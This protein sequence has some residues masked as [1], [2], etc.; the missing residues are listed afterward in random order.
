MAAI[1]IHLRR[2][3]Q[4]RLQRIVRKT[5]D[6]GL[7][8]RSL[9]ILHATA[10]KSTGQIAEAIGYDPSAVLKVIHRFRAEGE[11]GLRDHPPA[12]RQPHVDAPPPPILTPPPPRPPPPHG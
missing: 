3:E 6:A 7:R 10:G 1:V 4:R 9:I 12:N 2:W 8:T 5:G 11:D